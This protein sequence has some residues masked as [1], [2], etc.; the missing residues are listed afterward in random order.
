MTRNEA[1]KELFE[2]NLY[3]MFCNTYL[4]DFSIE[5]KNDEFTVLNRKNKIVLKDKLS[6]YDLGFES[7]KK[8]IL[9]IVKKVARWVEVIEDL[10]DKYF[11]NLIE[12][13][14]CRFINVLGGGDIYLNAKYVEKVFSNLD[15]SNKKDFEKYNNQINYYIDEIVNKLEKYDIEVVMYG[16]NRNDIRFYVDGFIYK[17]EIYI[18]FIKNPEK[19]KGI[20]DIDDLITYK[21]ITLY[22]SLATEKEIKK[23]I[24]FIEKLIA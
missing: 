9:N 12:T 3:I 16:F 18:N 11:E 17:N 14:G 15:L 4:D 5:F 8:F 24:K 7:Q 6:N 21:N 22:Y 13:D 23:A 19:L 1:L 10:D 20:D 2:E